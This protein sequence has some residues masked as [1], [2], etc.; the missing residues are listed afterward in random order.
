MRFASFRQEELLQPKPPPPGAPW[1]H[2]LS[3]TGGSHCGLPGLS[4]TAGVCFLSARYP[5]NAK[6]FKQVGDLDAKL[7]R[8]LATLDV[9]VAGVSSS[10]L[11]PSILL[12][13]PSF[14]CMTPYVPLPTSNLKP[15]TR[16]LKPQTLHPKPYTR[17][18]KPE[19]RKPKP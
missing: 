2:G 4:P 10:L 9:I 17:S 18:P 6:P 11:N 13:N 8:V 16:N 1:G 5:C 15:Y 14:P 7:E 19:T 12:L 3:P